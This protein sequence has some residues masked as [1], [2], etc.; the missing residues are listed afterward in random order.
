ISL[1]SVVILYL[2][3]LEAGYLFRWKPSF[4]SSD[5]IPLLYQ[6]RCCSQRKMAS[7]KCRIYKEFPDFSVQVFLRNP[8]VFHSALRALGWS[9]SI[10]DISQSTSRQERSRTSDCFLGH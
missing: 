10:P 9:I 1:F 8:Y 2:S 5:L 3:A 7:E 4:L 6:K